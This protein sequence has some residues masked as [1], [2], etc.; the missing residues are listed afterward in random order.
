MKTYAVRPRVFLFNY[1]ASLAR[2][3]KSLAGCAENPGYERVHEA[4][5]AIRRLRVA[6]SLLP[7]NERKDIRTVSFLRHLDQFYRVT[8]KLADYEAA[9]KQFS[10]ATSNSGSDLR[11]PSMLKERAGLS[12]RTRKLAA[13]LGHFELPHVQSGDLSSEKLTG[14]LLKEASRSVKRIGESHAGLLE[15]PHDTKQLHRLRRE[16]RRLRYLLPYVARPKKYAKLKSFLHQLQD[17]AGAIRDCDGSS[18]LLKD[19]GFTNSSS[20]ILRI[21]SQREALYAE[22]AL[23][24]LTPLEKSSLFGRF[25]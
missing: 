12:A 9:Q 1:N 11:A 22:F 14:R 7:R 8:T 15:D 2:T 4:R 24:Y 3:K 6:C 19:S 5:A 10:A 13:A 16:S 25:A 21:A 20:A 23:R 17:S 18:K